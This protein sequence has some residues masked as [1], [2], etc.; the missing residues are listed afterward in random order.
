MTEAGSDTVRQSHGAAM[1]RRAAARLAAV[2]ALYQIEMTGVAVERAIA[3]FLDGDRPQPDGEDED[4]AALPAPDPDLF[5]SVVRGVVSKRAQ[6]DELIAGAL[7]ADWTVA[8]LEIL[9]RLILEA[10][11]YEITFRGDIPVKASINE[12]LNVSNAFFNG[13]E[14]GLINAVLDAVA[15]ATGPAAPPKEQA[16]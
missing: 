5:T 13:A 10:G 8:R 4:L 16:R 2:Q 3:E 9:V 6:L 15:K 1:R 7:S 11:I 14:P 12:Y